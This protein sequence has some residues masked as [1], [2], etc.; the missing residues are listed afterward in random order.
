MF[1]TNT[2]KGAHSC[3]SNE[4]NKRKSTGVEIEKGPGQLSPF[5]NYR[6]DPSCVGSHC[7]DNI[8]SDTHF[9]F[10][11]IQI[12]HGY[13]RRDKEVKIWLSVFMNGHL[14]WQILRDMQ[15]RQALISKEHSDFKQP[16]NILKSL[17]VWPFSILIMEQGKGAFPKHL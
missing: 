1:A 13:N 4:I 8:C 2:T 3:K 12:F 11:T 16:C 10:S 9:S 15:W 5:W 17:C 7:Q 14:P 6:K